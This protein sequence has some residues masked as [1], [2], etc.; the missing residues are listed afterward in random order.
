MNVRELS[1]FLHSQRNEY[2]EKFN[3][4]VEFCNWLTKDMPLMVRCALE[5]LDDDNIPP[6]MISF[7]LFYEDM[8]KSSRESWK[9]SK[10]K[11]LQFELCVILF[12]IAERILY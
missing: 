3:S 12:F 8:I 1:R 2:R 10:D 11:S 9:N 7:V 4:L 5:D 6:T